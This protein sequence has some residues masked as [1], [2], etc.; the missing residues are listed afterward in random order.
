MGPRTSDRAISCTKSKFPSFFWAEW[1]LLFA[2]TRD[3]QPGLHNLVHC[4]YSLGESWFQM[5]GVPHWLV[6][7]RHQ[8]PCSLPCLQ[9]QRTHPSPFWRISEH[10]LFSPYPP[11]I[12]RGLTELAGRFAKIWEVY[13]LRPARHQSATPRAEQSLSHL[14]R[15]LGQ[16]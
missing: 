11:T 7:G 3:L 16:F 6:G 8:P 5:G 15:A 9:A 1:G 2:K 12:A 4:I 14:A 13:S 10:F